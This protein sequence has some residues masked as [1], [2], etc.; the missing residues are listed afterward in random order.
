MVGLDNVGL[1]ENTRLP[2]PVSFVRALARFAE[3]GV[4]RNVDTFVPSPVT[5]ASAIFAV[6]TLAEKLPL[7]SR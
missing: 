6:I 7:A 3:V 1:V 5:F 4:A 2:E